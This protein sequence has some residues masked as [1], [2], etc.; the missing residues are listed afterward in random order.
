MKDKNGYVYPH[1]IFIKFM[2]HH[3]YGYSFLGVF[4]KPNSIYFAELEKPIKIDSIFFFIT[5]QAGRIFEV[6]KNCDKYLGL[7]ATLLEQLTNF[8]E[9]GLNVHHFNPILAL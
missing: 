7:S 8:L 6:S 1:R 4:R 3:T 9:E 5:N 2:Y